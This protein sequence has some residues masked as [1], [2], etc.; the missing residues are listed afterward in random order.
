M[1]L[2]LKVFLKMLYFIALNRFGNFSDLWQ[3][4]DSNTRLVSLR[5]IIV[6]HYLNRDFLS[7]MT[8][9]LEVFKKKLERKIKEQEHWESVV[10]SSLT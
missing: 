7:E 8:S 9:N 6:K 10:W 4:N 3:F 5:R 2:L 1:A